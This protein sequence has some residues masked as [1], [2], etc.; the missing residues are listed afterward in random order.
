ML[1]PVSTLPP[2]LRSF[3]MPPAKRPPSCGATPDAAPPP[4]SPPSLLLLAL[5]LL[6]GGGA[7]PPGDGLEGMPG[8]FGAEPIVGAGGPSETFPTIGADRSLTTVTFLSLAPCSILLR[9]APYAL[10]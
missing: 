3:G 10:S 9:S 5:E 8:T 1:A 7:S 2:V 4:P 6:G